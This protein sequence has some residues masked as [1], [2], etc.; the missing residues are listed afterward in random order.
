MGSPAVD[1]PLYSTND[2]TNNTVSVN[3]QVYQVIDNGYVYGTP[4]AACLVLSDNAII[5]NPSSFAAQICAQCFHPEGAPPVPVPDWIICSQPVGLY[6]QFIKFKPPWQC[7]CLQMIGYV[8]ID[9]TLID[10]T[11]TFAAMCGA[12]KVPPPMFQIGLPVI[13]GAAILAAAAFSKYMDYSGDLPPGFRS[14]IN[15]GTDAVEKK[16]CPDNLPGGVSPTV[17][18]KTD[19]TCK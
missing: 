8:S 17:V 13:G 19:P 10:P 14:D 11:S 9:M 12:P 3:G 7:H 4:T 16:T 2:V 15:M 5:V 18:D 6:G 1:Q